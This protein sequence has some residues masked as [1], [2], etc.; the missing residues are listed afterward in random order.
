MLQSKNLLII[1]LV[2]PILVLFGIVVKTEYQ[3]RTGTE[4]E[5]PIHGYDPRDLLSGYYLAYSVDYGIDVCSEKD[6]QYDAYICL[7]PREF[8]A[9][10]PTDCDL[11]I[12][13]SC[14]Y[15]R[16]DAGVD[17]FYASEFTAQQLQY[18]IKQQPMS[19]ILSIS[20]GGNAQVKY[21]VVDGKRWQAK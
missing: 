9:T 7:N 20:E 11:F 10:K 12:K 2:I 1:A 8:S 19:I 21:L 3:F 15:G 13:G 4:V 17:R 16:F 14:N 5:L 18:L 6:R